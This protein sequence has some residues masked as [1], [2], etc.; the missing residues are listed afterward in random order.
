MHINTQ[1][2]KQGCIER[3]INWIALSNQILKWGC[4]TLL[5]KYILFTLYEYQ[6]I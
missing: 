6:L 2:F 4:E 3:V 1:N 5:I